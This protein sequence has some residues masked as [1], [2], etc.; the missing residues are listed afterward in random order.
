M[1]NT[2]N[3]FRAGLWSPF[4]LE[5]EGV[6][7]RSMANFIRCM[8]VSG[9]KPNEIILMREIRRGRWVR[10]ATPCSEHLEHVSRTDADK[11]G[12]VRAIKIAAN[13][14]VLSFTA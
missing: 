7:L 5:A 12:T 3:T 13:R 9:N 2:K 1:A 6:S 10:K 11:L 14:W 8:I 4:N